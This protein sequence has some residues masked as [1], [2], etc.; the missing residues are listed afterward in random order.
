MLLPFR[1]QSS[2]LKAKLRLAPLT[3]EQIAPILHPSLRFVALWAPRSPRSLSYHLLI[4]IE[5]S[6][7]IVNNLYL[8]GGCYGRLSFAI[9]PE[10]T[11]VTEMI[12]ATDWLDTKPAEVLVTAG[13]GHFVATIGFHDRVVARWTSLGA[14]K[15]KHLVEGITHV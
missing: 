12:I 3:L 13:T 11:F 5:L 1:C 10:T 15:Y 7:E 6:I 2:A 4:V 14:L 8:R 9:V